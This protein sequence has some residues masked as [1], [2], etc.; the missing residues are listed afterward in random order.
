[1]RRPGAVPL[2]RRRA[3]RTLP[4]SAGGAGPTWTRAGRGRSRSP[5]PPAPPPDAVFAHQGTTLQRHGVVQ[6]RGSQ[7]VHGLDRPGHGRLHRRRRPRHLH[8]AADAHVFTLSGT[9]AADSQAAH[10]L[11]GLRRRRVQRSPLVGGTG[12]L[13]SALCG[14]G[15]VDAGE[16]CDPRGRR[17]RARSAAASGVRPSRRYRLR[18]RRRHL[19]PR[20]LRRHWSLHFRT[21]RGTLGSRAAR[22]V[23]PCDVAEYA[24]G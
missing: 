8:L 20:R 6:R 14:N 2:R 12:T 3:Q 21:P 19:H 18:G 13:L 17:R 23:R 24:T 1:M 9:V 7:P 11:A 15:S 22:K 16:A 5:A 10:R 4:S